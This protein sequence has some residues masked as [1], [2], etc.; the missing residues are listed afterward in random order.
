MFIFIKKYF[1]WYWFLKM[2]DKDMVFKLKRRIGKVIVDIG[3]YGWDVLIWIVWFLKII[4]LVIGFMIKHVYWAIRELVVDLYNIITEFITISIF[5]IVEAIKGGNRVVLAII[6][7]VLV[8]IIIDVIGDLYQLSQ[9]IEEGKHTFIDTFKEWIERLKNMRWLWIF[10]GFGIGFGSCLV[11]GAGYTGDFNF[12]SEAWKNAP[13]VLRIKT[14]NIIINISNIM[15][16]PWWRAIVLAIVIEIT[17]VVMIC[18]FLPSDSTICIVSGGVEVEV[19]PKLKPSA[20][21]SDLS[22]ANQ[23]GIRV[24]LCICIVQIL[25]GIC[26]SFSKV[27][28]ETE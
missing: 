23:I 25:L 10:L 24:V 18:Q 6:H 17:I 19:K 1:V 22:K 28:S 15:S 5:I 7:V 26:I 16:S 9:D 20:V 11:I 27:E 21:Q 8:I 4:F 3:W 12:V 13:N 14:N 2:K